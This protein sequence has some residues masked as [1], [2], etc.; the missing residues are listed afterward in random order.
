MNEGGAT[1]NEG[2]ATVKEGGATVNEGG[3]TVKEGGVSTATCPPTAHAQ[4]V[5]VETETCS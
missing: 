1:V 2:G 5:H 4:L 3:A